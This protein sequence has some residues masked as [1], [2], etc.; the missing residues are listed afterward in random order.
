MANL[1]ILEAIDVAETVEVPVYSNR[2]GVYW[3]EISKRQA[4]E[5]IEWHD[6]QHMKVSDVQVYLDIQLEADEKGV[7]RIGRKRLVDLDSFGDVIR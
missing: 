6:L 2:L 4:T 5:L 3:V 7:L 1:N